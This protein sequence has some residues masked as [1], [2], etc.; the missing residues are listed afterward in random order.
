[1]ADSGLWTMVCY[2]VPSSEGSIIFTDK[3][4]RPGHV[5][6]SIQLFQMF[7]LDTRVTP[8]LIGFLASAA[9]WRVRFLRNM[10]L[11]LGYLCAHPIG[12]PYADTLLY[13]IQNKD[14][15]TW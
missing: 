13:D 12:A 11:G 14:V 15:S 10:L 7:A 6:S 3:D 9:R 4:E 5:D 8:Y 1:M 2:N